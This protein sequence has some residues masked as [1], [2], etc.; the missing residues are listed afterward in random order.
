MWCKDITPTVLKELLE[1]SS[2]RAQTCRGG[3]YT[4]GAW[5]QQ[6]YFAVL[7]EGWEK[8]PTL[9]RQYAGLSWCHC[10]IPSYILKAL[11]NGCNSEVFLNPFPIAC[12]HV[13]HPFILRCSLISRASAQ[14]LCVIFFPPHSSE[15]PLVLLL[16]RYSMDLFSS[17]CVQSTKVCF[18][19]CLWGRLHVFET[20]FLKPQTKDHFFKKKKY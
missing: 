11:T 20:Y 16:W 19:C 4:G 1:L 15:F 12:H 8:H 10:G 18:C 5:R 9:I 6:L 14:E 13:H 3:C 7:G 17:I 2:Q